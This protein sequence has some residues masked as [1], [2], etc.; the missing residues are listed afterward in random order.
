MRLPDGASILAPKKVIPAERF[1]L[2]DRL[3]DAALDRPVAERSSWLEEACG[4]DAGLRV[5]VEALLRLAESDKPLFESGALSGPIWDDV[6]SELE[7]MDELAPG[8]RVGSYEIRGLIG[9]GGMGAVYRAKDATLERE[10]AIKALTY[11][12]AADP[13]T[14]RRFERE[15]KLLASL[16]HPNIAV[17]HDL[18]QVEDRSYLVLELVEGETLSQR[19]ARGPI[20]LPEVIRIATQLA[21]ALEEAHRKGVVHR[22]LKPSNVKLTPEG[23]VK[24]LDFGLAKTDEPAVEEGGTTPTA[25]APTTRSGVILGTPG[26]MSP[27]QVRGHAVDKRSDIWAFGCLVYEMRVGTRAFAGATASDAIAAA[28]REEVDWSRLPRS[29]PPALERMLRRCLKQDARERLQDIGDARI[30]LEELQRDDKSASRTRATFA[31]RPSASALVVAT[32]FG[33]LAGAALLS[34]LDWRI[35]T[36]RKP[37]LRMSVLVGPGERLWQG[38]SSS[39]AISPDGSRVAFVGEKEERIS[40]FVR[41]LDAYD[42]VPVR[43][44]DGARDPFFSPDGEWV[45]FFAGGEMRRVHLA[46]GASSSIT[47]A[48]L[49][50]RGASWGA[51]ERIVFSQDG[52]KGLFVV[53]SAG[54][55]AELLAAPDP[56]DD[57]V[58]YLWPQWLPEQRSVL[59]TR[60][61]LNASGIS[62]ELVVLDLASARVQAIGR[63]TQGVFVPSGHVVYATGGSL[64]AV[65][66][67][68]ESLTTT[69]GSVQVV[70]SVHGYPIGA[71]SFAV[72]PSGALLYVEPT[73][74]TTLDWVDRAGTRIP[75]E[76]P[77]GTPGW[78]RLS[79]DG[80]LAALHVGGPETRD[81]WLLDLERPGSTR[82]LTYRG[83][84]FPVWSQDGQRIGFMSRQA[85]SGDLYIVPADGSGPPERVVSGERT[86]IPVSWSR[87]GVLAY[88]EIGEETQR[89]IWV[90]D[91]DGDRTPRPFVATQANE[92]SPVFSPDGRRLAYVSDESGQNEVYVRPYPPPGAVTVISI[93]GGS[94][95]VWSR[96]G[97]QLFYRHA[98]KLM[99]V[100]VRY[101]PRFEVGRPATAMDA[102]LLPGSGGNPSYDIAGDGSRFLVLRSAAES[103]VDELRLVL[104]WGEELRRAASKP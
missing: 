54:G 95:P 74:T 62:D 34:I 76:I 93:D 65:G 56:G 82:Q 48:S 78:P 44:S 70:E 40:L 72:S 101:S 18:L 60:R 102:P 87:D 69:G 4:G 24:V 2:V 16:N 80:H 1:S 35:P 19:L 98:D 29:T 88:Y 81:V 77:R 53:P 31:W 27:E 51:D 58:E 30:E 41:S 94:E 96:D 14:L 43:S 49:Q 45:G 50:S 86:K 89:D 63:G 23:R 67:D 11:A 8:D 85:G 46:S 13:S 83:G 10:V 5:E 32:L 36:A 25:E 90:V 64:E 97:A 33:L 9:R 104:N 47:H 15:A 75:L 61:R 91:L 21:D 68:L 79:P 99:S 66:L 73:Q 6:L 17:I 103:S 57:V 55:K 92:L 7:S 28:L 71:T 37:L 39:I 12:F 42:A 22:N 20:E 26:Y 100:S 38:A 52:A 3:F 84:G 59:F